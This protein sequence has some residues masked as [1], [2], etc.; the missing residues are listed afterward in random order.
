MALGGLEKDDVTKVEMLDFLQQE[1]DKG[2]ETLV[3]EE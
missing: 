3:K 2:I 1:I